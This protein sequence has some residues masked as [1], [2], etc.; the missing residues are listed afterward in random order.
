M[1]KIVVYNARKQFVLFNYVVSVL[2]NIKP[3][4]SAVYWLGFGSP[5]TALDLHSHSNFQCF[6][7]AEIWNLLCFG[8]IWP[9]HCGNASRLTD[10][11][12]CQE[13]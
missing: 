11:V 2:L 12:H 5:E 13:M 1:A 7:L 10:A 6:G 4:L 8:R 9:S 3:K